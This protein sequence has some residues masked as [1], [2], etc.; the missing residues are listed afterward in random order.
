MPGP[1]KRLFFKPLSSTVF[2]EYT[3]MGPGGIARTNAMAAPIKN[4]AITK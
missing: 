4:A 2:I 1:T 3:L